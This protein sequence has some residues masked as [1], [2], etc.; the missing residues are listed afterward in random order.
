MTDLID[1]L[2][3][4][5]KERFGSLRRMSLAIGKSQNYFAEYF[6]KEKLPPPFA[7][8]KLEAF[9]LP[10]AP[11]AHIMHLSGPTDWNPVEPVV[12]VPDDLFPESSAREEYENV[13]LYGGKPDWLEL[14]DELRK[15]LE[16]RYVFLQLELKEAE[17]AY[18]RALERERLAKNDRIAKAVN[19]YRRSMIMQLMGEEP[20]EG[21]DF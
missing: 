11:F 17:D 20:R 2:K 21:A 4:F 14:P 9:G 8:R 3:S 13:E 1:L 10:I 5:A 15:K 19:G 6:A 16:Q 7:L 18:K 12:H